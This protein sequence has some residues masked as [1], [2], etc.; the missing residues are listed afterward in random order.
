MEARPF[1]RL[2]SARPAASMR[3]VQALVRDLNQ[4][5]RAVP[6]LHELDCEGAGFEWLVARRR[7][8]QRV[9]LAAQ[10]QRRPRAL[11]LSPSI[12]R[13][14]CGTTT[15]SAC[16][17]PAPGAKC[18]TPT[19]RIYGG[20]NVGNA[21]AVTHVAT[22]ATAPELRLVVPPLAADLSRSGALAC[23]VSAG[24]PHPLGATWDGRGTNFALFSAHAE[25]VELCLFD[26]QRAAA[27]SSASLCRSAPSDVWHGYLADVAP[28]PALRLSRARTL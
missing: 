22:A 5:Y 24:A 1:A 17:S 6:A 26:R 15:A 10:G 20:S 7:R 12:S 9:R 11:R 23:G 19:R 28:G 8:Q 4:L 16:R 18:S 27:R 2:A 13:R 21:G 3:G 25:K 14:R